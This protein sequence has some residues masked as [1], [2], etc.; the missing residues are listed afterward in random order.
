MKASLHS[1]RNGEKHL[2]PWLLVWVVVVFCRTQ[3]GVISSFL[4]DF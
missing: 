1:A 2:L 4:T 3:D